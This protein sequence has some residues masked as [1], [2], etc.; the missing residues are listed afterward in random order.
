VDNADTISGQIVVAQAL[1]ELLA[2]AK[3]ASYG[4]GSGAS[5]VVPTP[6]PTASASPSASA[7]S[8]VTDPRSARPSASS[9][10]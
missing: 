2:K 4:T 1:Y 6:M 5:A 8:V 9:H 10:Q 7:G 3:P